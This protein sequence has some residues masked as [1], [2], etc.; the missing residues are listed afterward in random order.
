MTFQVDFEPIGRRVT[1]N[2]GATLLDA[3][4]EAGVMLTAIC[5]GEGSCGRCIVRVMSGEVS[6]PNDTEMFE[7][8]RDD[9]AAGWRLACQTAIAS[10]VRVHVPPDS[11]VTA[12][13]TQTEGQAI[14]V[15]HAPAV[16]AFDLRLPPP[17]QEDLR[18][19]AARLRDAL[20][21]GG[22]RPG[23]RPTRSAASAR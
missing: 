9:V 4:Q 23:V 19:D 20:P 2:A 12:Q 16:R 11:L 7:L 21:T 17:T 3:A 1:C 18:S 8:G 10:D 14:A 13:R 22:A 5:G 15:E 6:P